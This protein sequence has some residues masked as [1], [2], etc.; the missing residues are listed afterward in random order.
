MS[1]LVGVAERHLEGTAPAGVT[2]KH[3][4]PTIGTEV[5]GLDLRADLDGD[6]VAFLRQLF[7]DRKALLF[8]QDNPL[9]RDD[10]LRFARHFGPLRRGPESV[11]YGQG[12]SQEAT[13][14]IYHF[15]RGQ[16]NLA[17]ESY[18]HTDQP[19]ANPPIAANVAVIRTKPA[20]GGETVFADMGAAYD[21]LSPWL[22][23]AISGLRAVH[24]FSENV[25]EFHPDMSDEALARWQEVSRPKT[26]PLVL[27]HPETGR[28]IL[29]VTGT[30]TLSVVGLPREESRMLIDY[31][32]RRASVPEY[33]CRFRWA[34]NALGMWDNRAVQHYGCFDYPNAER[35]LE[36]IHVQ[37][38]KPWPGVE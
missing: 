26:L 12:S 25:R 21:G 29:Y 24:G 20:I 33:Q 18:W 38:D 32:A 14:E 23:T 16:G 17:R 35:V 28:K 8:F 5:Y 19:Y 36:G 34:D 31:L 7:L 2:L 22:K 15:R 13:G 30:Y 6:V 1:D 10:H 37:G 3:L 11:P 27:D 9:S 4:A